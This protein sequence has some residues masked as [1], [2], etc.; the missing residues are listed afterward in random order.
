MVPDFGSSR[1]ESVMS[2]VHFFCPRDVQERLAKGMQQTAG[3]MVE[4]KVIKVSRLLSGEYLVGW[5][6]DYKVYSF[7]DWKPVEIGQELRCGD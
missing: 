1:G 6:G 5:G 3:L 7:M 2:R 4:Y